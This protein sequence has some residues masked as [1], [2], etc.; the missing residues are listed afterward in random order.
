[1]RV[2]Y[3]QSPYCLSSCLIISSFSGSVR[4]NTRKADVVYVTLSR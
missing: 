4:G 1:L 2:T 3:A